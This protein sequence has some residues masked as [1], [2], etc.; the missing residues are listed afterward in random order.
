M[1]WNIDQKIRLIDAHENH[2]LTK[3]LPANAIVWLQCLYPLN[4]I[5]LQPL[6]VKSAT[7]HKLRN[8]KITNYTGQ[9]T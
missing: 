2:P 6:L 1:P 4:M 5:G 8:L 7:Y 3:L 9:V